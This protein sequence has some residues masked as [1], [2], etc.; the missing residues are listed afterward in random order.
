[1]KRLLRKLKKEWKITYKDENRNKSAES[2]HRR[3]SVP[4]L[5]SQKVLHPRG[6]H[7]GVI[8]DG[9]DRQGTGIYGEDS[10]GRSG[11]YNQG[12]SVTDADI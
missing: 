9:I 1:M 4:V 6:D 3:R 5:A 10:R 12:L 2:P 7:P 8:T 11:R